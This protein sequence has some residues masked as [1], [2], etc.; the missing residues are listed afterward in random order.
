MTTCPCC[1]RKA[2]LL[3]CGLCNLC[4]SSEPLVEAF[5]SGQENLRLRAEAGGVPAP[6]VPTP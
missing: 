3:E 2:P 5:T 6:V 1:E 4:A